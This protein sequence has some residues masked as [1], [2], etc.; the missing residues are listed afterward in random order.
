MAEIL[1]MGGGGTTIP[2][3]GG[4]AVSPAGTPA[5]TPTPVVV[6]T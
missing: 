6:Q 3:G 1:E 5:P 2:S 4:E